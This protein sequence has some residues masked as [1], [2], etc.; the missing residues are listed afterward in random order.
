MLYVCWTLK[1]KRNHNFNPMHQAVVQL[2]NTI[3]QPKIVD[4]NI[5]NDG[6]I[7]ILSWQCYNRYFPVKKFSF[8]E[9]IHIA[10]H[11]VHTCFDKNYAN[12]IQ[13]YYCFLNNLKR[14]MQIRSIKKEKKRMYFILHSHK[15]NN[16]RH[17]KGLHCAQVNFVFIIK[18]WLLF[19]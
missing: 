14:K 6:Q 5:Q 3:N 10:L 13:I 7:S 19:L 8:N 17:Y 12:F 11:K 9:S 18:F 15:Y 1:L 4:I 2:F 16:I